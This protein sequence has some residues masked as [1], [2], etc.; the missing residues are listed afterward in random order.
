MLKIT[1]NLQKDF[2][3]PNYMILELNLLCKCIFHCYNLT[4]YKMK[5]IILSWSV[6]V[7][8]MIFLLE[9]PTFY[10]TLSNF[11]V[12]LKKTPCLKAYFSRIR[13]RWVN[14]Y[15]ETFWSFCYY[16]YRPFSSVSETKKKKNEIKKFLRWKSSEFNKVPA[17]ESSWAY[18][19]S[20]LNNILN[21]K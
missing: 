7:L 16:F 10:V 11:L 17:T 9:K 6:I 12:F 19:D 21:L 4:L 3:E 5:C 20:G 8:N 15:S 1:K 14:V 18:K 13:K 2:K